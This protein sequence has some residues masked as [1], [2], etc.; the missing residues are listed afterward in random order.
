MENQIK[1]ICDKC[2]QNTKER[3]DQG[4]IIH[5]IKRAPITMCNC[6]KPFTSEC[7][8]NGLF[9]NNTFII[10]PVR[11]AACNTPQER[12]NLMNDP[13]AMIKENNGNHFPIK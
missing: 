13:S 10:D 11:L 6:G 1:T 3:N 7:S 8:R 4:Q 5:P 9:G 2:I 12:I